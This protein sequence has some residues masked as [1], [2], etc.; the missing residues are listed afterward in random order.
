MVKIEFPMQGT[1]VRSLVWELRSHMLLSVAKKKSE[2]VKEK[3]NTCGTHCLYPLHIVRVLSMK[4]KPAQAS[5]PVW[6]EAGESGEWWPSAQ[7][8]ACGNCGIM[9]QTP[10][11]LSPT[12]PSG[13]AYS[14]QGSGL[15]M[16]EGH[17]ALPS[18][19]QWW[20]RGRSSTRWVWTP[21]GL[22]PTELSCVLG[23]GSFLL[24]P[25]LHRCPLAPFHP[26]GGFLA[27]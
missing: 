19:P 24:T 18:S 6:S 12:P 1:Q 4:K 3:A 13:I 11:G 25:L 10:D 8:S 23:L 9:G 5:G 2:Y 26:R 27:S 20:C 7:A 15:G 21:L 16:G 22:L 14:P 17:F